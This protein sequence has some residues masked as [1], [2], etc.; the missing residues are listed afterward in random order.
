MDTDGPIASDVCLLEGNDF[1]TE[2]LLML[3]LLV[4]FRKD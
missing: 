3:Q 1:C 4:L 2:A